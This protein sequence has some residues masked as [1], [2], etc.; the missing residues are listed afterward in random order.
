[1]KNLKGDLSFVITNKCNQKCKFCFTRNDDEKRV[2]LTVENIRDI[3]I[4]E[5][6]LFNKVFIMGG[7]PT[8]HPFF[9]EIIDM[10]N[11]EG[12]K[13][14]TLVSNGNSLNNKDVISLLLKKNVK[15]FTIAFHDS[16]PQVFGEVTRNKNA[17]Y[18]T[19]TAIKNILECGGELL[20]NFFNQNKFRKI[21]KHN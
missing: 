5:K 7:E 11:E 10:L 18:H 6:G 21:N 12:C 14:I 9:N 15:N 3:I 2:D 19:T 16:D 8:F 4:R 1:M 13:N 17:F 20:I